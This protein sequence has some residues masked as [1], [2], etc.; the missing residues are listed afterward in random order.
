MVNERVIIT[1]RVRA[2]LVLPDA[3]FDMPG[4]LGI[5]Q[6]PRVNNR[7]FSFDDFQIARFA[8]NR[9]ARDN[10][11]RFAEKLS[12]NLFG[13][14]CVAGLPII[15]PSKSTTVSAPTTIE[16]GILFG[17]VFAL[18]KAVVSNIRRN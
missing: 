5:G 8:D 12:R 1:D 18:A 15:C 6:L 4:N 3:A 11:V 7:C 2:G 14:F 9:K 13:V 16:S 17:N 10:L